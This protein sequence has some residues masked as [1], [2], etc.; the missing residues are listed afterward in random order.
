MRFL[1]QALTCVVLRRANSE[2][3]DEIWKLPSFFISSST[4]CF[5][6]PSLKPAGMEPQ[7]G[8]QG[9]GGTAR[10]KGASVGLNQ[11]LACP[12]RV[13]QAQRRAMPIQ[14]EALGDR[15]Q[16]PPVG[17]LCSQEYGVHWG[18]R[19]DPEK[20][21]GARPVG[22]HDHRPQGASQEVRRFT[23]VVWSSAYSDAL[24]GLLCDHNLG[25]IHLSHPQ[26]TG[27]RHQTQESSQSG[28]ASPL[29]PR[30]SCHS[31]AIREPWPPAVHWCS[32]LEP[33]GRHAR[34]RQEG[35]TAK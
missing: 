21:E 14:G 33:L 20:V 24:P 7:E 10:E 6:W 16:I 19:A 2:I 8:T 13:G 22:A 29:N 23:V 35:F 9:P 12:G 3:P 30:I 15:S 1:Q 5:S 4:V 34:S 32:V 26:G 28:V 25:P 27:D 17:R 31:R 11:G 18:D